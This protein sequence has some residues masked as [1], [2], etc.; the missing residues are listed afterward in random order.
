MRSEAGSVAPLG[1]GMAAILLA[2]V[3]T[4]TSA[5]SLYLLSA[6]LT[7]VAE[8]A[9]LSEVRYSTSAAD[10][11]S[12]TQNTDRLF[13]DED[14]SV[15]LI[16]AEVTICTFWTSPVP[17]LSEAGALKVCGHGAAREG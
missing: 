12:S 9:A 16:T 3:F 14:S 1:I 17:M 10:F 15:D 6:R 2:A 5:N 11:L 8:F 4:L 7:A 13:V